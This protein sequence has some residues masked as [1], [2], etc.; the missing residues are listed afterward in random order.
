MKNLP[1]SR[2]V[3]S[4]RGNLINVLHILN[5]LNWGKYIH[6]I[7]AN[8]INVDKDI[9]GPEITNINTILTM[10]KDINIFKQAREMNYP[11]IIYIDDDNEIMPKR[12]PNKNQLVTFSI[13]KY[14][15]N[16]E[17]D[18]VDLNTGDNDISNIPQ[19][20]MNNKIGADYTR[21][22]FCINLPYETSSILNKAYYSII[23]NLF[24][25][26]SKIYNNVL[27]VFDFDNTLTQHHLFKSITSNYP[28]PKTIPAGLTKEVLQN[29]FANAIKSKMANNTKKTINKQKKAQKEVIEFYIGKN[30]E[31]NKI[32]DLFNIIKPLSS[33]TV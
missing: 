19:F 13:Y 8:K 32:K 27:T 10:R 2:I 29:T 6:T 31:I 12:K 21:Y 17:I 3:I 23:Q 25:Y 7:Y 26:I 22:C 18:Y 33:I 24:H 11:F 20:F 14:N 28:L 15:E 4:T 30:A 1:Q 9:F 5:F 16:Y